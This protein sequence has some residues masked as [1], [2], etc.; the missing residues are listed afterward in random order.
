M[1]SNQVTGINA[2][3]MYLKQLINKIF[4]STSSD[5]YFLQIIMCA[6]TGTQILA[7]VW[8]TTSI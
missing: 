7:T 6:I 3:I 1:I 4:E 2:I 5:P 8:A